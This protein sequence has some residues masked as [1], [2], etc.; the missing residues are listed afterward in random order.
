[1]NRKGM[2]RVE[3]L[4]CRP[5]VESMMD[6]GYSLRMVFDELAG[7]GR[8]SMSYKHFCRM[9]SQFRVADKEGMPVGSKVQPL[10]PR[11][12]PLPAPTTSTFSSRG[13]VPRVADAKVPEAAGDDIKKLLSRT[14]A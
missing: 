13:A 3:F 11:E 7:M 8:I 12:V 5:E 9:V 14:E 2:G 4:A 6:K 1:M 10:L